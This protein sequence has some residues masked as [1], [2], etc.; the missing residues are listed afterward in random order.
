MTQ[1]TKFSAL[2]AFGGDCDNVDP[3]QAAD[4]LRRA[5]YEVRRLPDKYRRLLDHPRDDFLEVIFPCVDDP[6]AINF[7]WKEIDR[8]ANPYAGCCDECGPLDPDDERFA[9]L[10]APPLRFH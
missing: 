6:K 2:V 10:F 5:G 9:D 1:Q 7:V 4:E 8:I 3:D